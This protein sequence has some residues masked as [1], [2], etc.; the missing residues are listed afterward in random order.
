MTVSP[1]DFELYSRVTGAPVPR[2]PQEQM[3]M[4]PQVYDFVRNRQYEPSKLQKAASFL[5][6]AALLGGAAYGANKLL[7]NRANNSER[8]T[9]NVDFTDIADN[10]SPGP[11]SQPPGPSN[12]PDS[13]P[14]RSNSPIT[15]PWEGS[16]GG[17]AAIQPDIS[18][19]PAVQTPVARPTI[20]ISSSYTPEEFSTGPDVSISDRA[21]QLA[22]RIQSQDAKI[23]SQAAD[24]NWI[25][26]QEPA[27]TPEVVDQRPQL[28]SEINPRGKTA[29]GRGAANLVE[30]VAT[31]RGNA[32]PTAA[33]AGG[34]VT[35]NILDAGKVLQGTDPASIGGAVGQTTTNLMNKGLG[36]YLD[37]TVGQI[38]A[39]HA[40]TEGVRMA[41]EGAQAVG[42]LGGG[43][44][45]N[46]ANWAGSHIY[47]SPV[48]NA[49]DAVGNVIHVGG[50]EAIGLGLVAG[51]GALG[52][53][54]MTHGRNLRAKLDPTGESKWFPT[55][56]ELMTGENPYGRFHDQ[57][58]VP[59]IR[60]GAEFT[61]DVVIP[62]LGAVEQNYLRPAGQFAI[63]KGWEADAAAKGWARSNPRLAPG[64]ERH[65][66]AVASL[67]RNVEAAFSGIHFDH[68]QIDQA[69][70]DQARIAPG[71][72]IHSGGDIQGRE[73]GLG[74][75][76][77]SDPAAFQWTGKSYGQ[78]A[79]NRLNRIEEI[80]RNRGI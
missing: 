10:D 80:R 56:H 5:G 6:K 69:G 54:V 27:V 52:G 20:D 23:Q 68:A 39:V 67:Q 18:P 71:A 33:A 70:D 19:E 41:G 79:V 63:R 44:V 9:V 21:V 58:L 12:R 55:R 45:G 49:I 46:A 29:L 60:S 78:E 40:M 61:R 31:A 11:G 13:P 36:G 3:Q 34:I 15:D 28:R 4:A 47:Q 38:P 1:A 32:I 76:V 16:G 73:P 26:H 74:A 62:S 51:A 59:A 35:H 57:Q 53:E 66:S 8:R 43:F 22:N 77:E 65:D 48:G 42:R 17:G 72:V 50:P 7:E 64:M 75:H 14:T 37:S 30:R 2:S 25:V 24:P